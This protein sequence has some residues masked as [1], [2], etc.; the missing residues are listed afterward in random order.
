MRGDLASPDHLAGGHHDPGPYVPV[1]DAGSA[2]RA[3]LDELLTRYP[4]KMAALLPSLWIVQRERG[5]VSDAAMSEVAT[6]LELTP[7]YVKGV[8]TFYTMYH[9]HPV[10][11]YFVQVC[12]TT[13]C[14]VCGAEGVVEA[15]LEHTRCGDLGVTSP[16]GRFTVIEVECLGACGFA[17]PVMI[18]E[19]FVESVTPDRVPQILSVL[20]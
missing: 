17:T 4:T 18:N 19:Q 16:D 1:F 8:V 5:W 12:T 10:G 6:L 7:A 20:P 2:P 13:P 14:N 11:K 9:Q 15:F 3:E